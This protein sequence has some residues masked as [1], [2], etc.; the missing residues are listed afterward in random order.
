MRAPLLFQRRYFPLW[1]AVSLGAFNDNMLRQALIIGIVYGGVAI[2]GF[3]DPADAI[4]VVGAAFSA[5]TLVCASAAG[6]IAERFES[7]RLLRRI[8]LVEVVLMVLAAVG[9]AL[10]AGLFLM[11]VFVAMSAQTAFFN[12][13]RAAAMPKYLHPHELVRGNA[14]CSAGMFAAVVAGLLAG[15]VLIA[16]PGGAAFV[17]GGLVLA[18]LLSWAATL[19][20]PEAAADAPSLR[21]RWDPFGQTIRTL[22]FAF[23]EAG[24]WRPLAGVAFF[25]LVST[26]TTI[27]TPL[28]AIEELGATGATATALM[29][30]V[31]I[32]AGAGA[33]A[34]ASVARRRSGL[35][36]SFVGAVVAGSALLAAAL[37][38]GPVAATGASRTLGALAGHWPGLALIA[39]FT[40][41]SASM[42]L[43]LVP[44]QAAAQRRAP[45]GRRARALAG[46]AVLNAL[47]AMTGALAVF[48]V[49]A[50]RLTPKD[51]L[52]GLALMLF[53]LA[54]YMALRWLALPQGLY[55]EALGP[56]R[57]E[58]S[59]GARAQTESGETPA[60]AAR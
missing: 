44:L 41:S 51:G 15:G 18:A 6:Q 20:L 38:T 21:I 48:V 50:T 2:A 16:M 47:F 25:Y 31:A 1:L 27:I 4:P 33:I 55:D 59:E 19:L 9:F 17:A 23:A 14:Y 34:A 58:A 22:R 11:A 10:K 8:K 54:G 29:G 30:L 36:L 3:S 32:G 40:L 43:Y 57:G 39:C 35:G 7:A 52:S 60:R 46:G 49:T 5:A 53:A 28:Y 56:R 26:V 37:L 45:P 24:V 12:P 13:A 42:G